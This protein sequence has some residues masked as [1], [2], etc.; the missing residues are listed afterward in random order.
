[1]T[2][3]RLFRHCQQSAA[4]QSEPDTPSPWIATSLALLAMTLR[5]NRVTQHRTHPPSLRAEGATIQWVRGMPGPVNCHVATLLAMTIGG[6]GTAQLSSAHPV[7]ASEAR[8]SSARRRP[9]GRSL[10]RRQV[11]G[12]QTVRNI[13]QWRN[14]SAPPPPPVPP[15]RLPYLR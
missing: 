7:I 9:R 10:A 8:Q 6:N 15:M 1:R 13:T 12:N 4:T 5:L 3:S 14:L 11:S 2:D